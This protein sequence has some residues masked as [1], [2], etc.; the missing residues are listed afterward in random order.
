M[1]SLA[2]AEALKGVDISRRYPHFYRQLMADEALRESFL[3]GLCLL[4]S[5]AENS[6]EPL[7]APPSVDLN[8]L[9]QTLQPKVLIEET[10][11]SS[12]R[13]I[14]QTSE[15]R[16]QESLH[17]LLLE[18]GC[19]P[20]GNYLTLVDDQV[21]LASHSV[22]ILLSLF[23]SLSSEDELDFQLVITAVEEM[24]LSVTIR[25]GEY[26]ISIPV[27][28]G[29]IELPPLSL[30]SILD[31]RQKECQGGLLLMLEACVSPDAAVINIAS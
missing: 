12:W 2:L 28:S 17:D 27:R 18:K 3:L 11:K 15:T 13:A 21:T 9:A 8:F 1:L 22:A 31:D 7:P 29:R 6:L 30:R 19:T 5:D 20:G 26:G 16:L 23:P 14:W 24:V 25:C 4:E 10:G